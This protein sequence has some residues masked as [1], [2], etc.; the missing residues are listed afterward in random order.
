MK[1]TRNLRIIAITVLLITGLN[2]LVAGLLFMMDPTGAKIGMTTTYLQYSPFDSFFIPGLVLFT[3]NGLMNLLA[4]MATIA[5]KFHFPYLIL[6]QGILLAGWIIIQM[7]MVRDVNFLHITML[8][9]ALVLTMV[10]LLLLKIQK[11][12]S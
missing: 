6:L 8:A 3:V 2:A 4:A 5:Q 9:F 7:L 11:K 1:Q 12:T 10:A